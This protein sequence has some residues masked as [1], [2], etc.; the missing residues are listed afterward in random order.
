MPEP[1]LKTPT[2]TPVG[3]LAFS[4]GIIVANIYYAQP[5]LAEMAHDF[6]VSVSGIGFVAMLSQIGTATGMLLFVPLGDNRERRSLIMLLLLAAFLS[7]CAMAT[8][9]NI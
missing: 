2:H 8:A 6:G 4:V 1:T 3:L 9:R 5:L 7:L